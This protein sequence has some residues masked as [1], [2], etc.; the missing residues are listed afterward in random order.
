MPGVKG[1]SG[2]KRDGAGPKA[3]PLKLGKQVGLHQFTSDGLKV[4][5][6]RVMRV[7]ERNKRKAVL[8]DEEGRIVL[9]LK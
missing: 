2:G 9:L 3:D 1:R 8:E 4:G 5:L 6:M 7:T